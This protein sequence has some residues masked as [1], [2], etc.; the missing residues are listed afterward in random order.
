MLT[1]CSILTS[2]LFNNPPV[3]NWKQ[4]KIL[5]LTKDNARDIK[6]K[7]FGYF[8][9]IEHLF[10]ESK[11]DRMYKFEDLKPGFSLPSIPEDKELLNDKKKVDVSQLFGSN[12]SFGLIQ[13]K[14]AGVAQKVN[15]SHGRIF[16]ERRSLYRAGR[17]SHDEGK[18]Q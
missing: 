15:F 5:K 16:G 2:T 13:K 18:K 10:D 14:G 17:S 12:K 11:G 4:K 6:L 3:F 9:D 7:K 1:K 8:V